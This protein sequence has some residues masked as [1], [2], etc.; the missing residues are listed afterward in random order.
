MHSH[1]QKAAWAD[2]VMLEDPVTHGA[3]CL[4]QAAETELPNGLQQER[5]TM[6]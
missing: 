3:E 4:Q 6:S 5:A 1:H 2:W